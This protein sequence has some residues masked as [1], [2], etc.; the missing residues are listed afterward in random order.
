MSE[1]K[2]V[3]EQILIN[4]IETGVYSCSCGE[5]FPCDTVKAEAAI[6]ADREKLI[7]KIENRICNDVHTNWY[8][9]LRCDAERAKV[10]ATIYLIRNT[11][12]EEEL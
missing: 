1:H 4:G 8:A 6:R 9:E 5:W 11:P 7:K 10:V 12:I 3:E 2:A